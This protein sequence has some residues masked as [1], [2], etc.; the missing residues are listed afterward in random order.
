M[1]KNFLITDENVSEY[2]SKI[3]QWI[4][5]KVEEANRKGVVLGMSGGIDC[6][7]VARLCQIGDVDCHLVIMPYENS[8]LS[9]GS[10]NSANELIEKFN[11]K[12]HIFNIN[13]TW[14]SIALTFYGDYDKELKMLSDANL[15]ARIRMVYLYQIAQLEHRFVIGTGNLSERFTGYCTK[16]GDSAC[17]LNPLGNLTKREVYTLA[18][19]LEIPESIINRPPSAGLWVGQ[20]DE[21]EMGFTY[22]ELD[23]FI[24]NGTSGKVPIDVVIKE[25]NNMSQHKLNPI[26]MFDVD[27]VKVWKFHSEEL[28]KKNV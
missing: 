6:S 2:A 18:R 12:H 14:N 26:P 28:K 20:T 25:R 22:N 19:F 3:G 15:K 4:K 23:D 5:S 17:D 1:L 13:T 16:W 11:F 9:D 8:M 10:L 21:E 7:V 27:W 24:L